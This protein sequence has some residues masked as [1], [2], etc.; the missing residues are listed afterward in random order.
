M[1]IGG[2]GSSEPAC[3]LDALGIISGGN[4]LAP[5]LA[6]NRVQHLHCFG[7]GLLHRFCR[8][9]PDG[10]DK[11]RMAAQQSCRTQQR[12]HSAKL[13]VFQ[14]SAAR[15]VGCL[16][17]LQVVD[18]GTPL[19]RE[20]LRSARAVRIR[21]GASCQDQHCWGARGS[22][23]LS[24][25]GLP[26]EQ[27]NEGKVSANV[28][29]NEMSGSFRS[30][31]T[32]QGPEHSEIRHADACSFSLPSLPPPLASKAGELRKEE[33]P[34]SIH[35]SKWRHQSLLDNCRLARH[36]WVK[37]SQPRTQQF[38]QPSWNC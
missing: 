5:H 29:L 8:L 21:R 34:S 22:N 17:S 7:R 20:V 31:Q 18:V 11:Q 1:L 3:H 9:E 10:A 16:C 6:I 15:A 32:G 12:F 37:N 25:S 23:P 2:R 27:S 30:V 38:L 24:P 33:T 36:A 19:V 26:K 35:I 14:L 28:E 13:H 4:A